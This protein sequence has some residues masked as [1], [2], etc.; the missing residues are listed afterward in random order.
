M[1]RRAIDPQ[2]LRRIKRIFAPLRAAILCAPMY[3]LSQLTTSKQPFWLWSALLLLFADIV[4][5]RLTIPAE[6]SGRNQDRGSKGTL[7]ITFL[8]VLGLGFYARGRGLC[9]P[10]PQGWEPAVRWSG[11][12]LLLVG[13][14]FRQWAIHSLGRHFTD[15]ARILQAH[16]LVERG[17]YRWI[18]HPSYTGLVMIFFGFAAYLASPVALLVCAVLLPL[19][20][21]RRVVVEEALMHDHFGVAWE[22][23]AATRG[24]LLPRLQG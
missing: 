2:K 3:W 16:Q 17:P 5:E 12:A 14:A 1:S 9:L 10:W 22:R 23:F 6:A 13:V 18:R 20:L 4:L 15:R 11:L 8:L 21:Y 19:S 7:G 24:R